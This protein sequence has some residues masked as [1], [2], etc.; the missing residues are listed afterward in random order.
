[1]TELPRQIV[2]REPAKVKDG[3]SFTVTVTVPV[4]EHV[5]AVL[6]KVK[7]KVFVPIGTPAVDGVKVEPD[8]P[9]PPVNDNEGPATEAPGVTKLAKFTADPLTQTAVE[10]VVKATELFTV[11][12]AVAVTGQFFES[13]AVKAIVLVEPGATS[14]GTKVAPLT[15]GPENV[16]PVKV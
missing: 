12:T 4:A 16:C 7:P 14:D 5:L 2:A 8:K 13:N 10:L 1:M 15:P 9:T 3:L 6:F 11:A